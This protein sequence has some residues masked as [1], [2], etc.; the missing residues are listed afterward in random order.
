MPLLSSPIQRSAAGSPPPRCPATVLLE[1]WCW[2]PGSCSWGRRSGTPGSPGPPARPS[3]SHRSSPVH[4]MVGNGHG[5][6]GTSSSST[7][8]L[9]GLVS[10]TL[11]PLGVYLGASC[12]LNGGGG[13]GVRSLSLDLG[14]TSDQLPSDV[15]GVL[16]S[17]IFWSDVTLSASLAFC[18]NSSSYMVLS[19]A[20]SK[21]SSSP[22]SGTQAGLSTVAHLLVVLHSGSP[23]CSVAYVPEFGFPLARIPIRCSAWPS[24]LGCR[25]SP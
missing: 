4:S 13:G 1:G 17:K 22:R 24:L 25:T 21:A 12:G 16:P 8:C 19:K 10:G 3:R 20:R 23:G 15:A 11:V 2:S 7:S 14:S 18:S 5:G 9:L 6:I